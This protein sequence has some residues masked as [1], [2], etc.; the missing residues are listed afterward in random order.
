MPFKC[1]YCYALNP[2]FFMIMAKRV[3]LFKFEPFFPIIW[4]LQIHIPLITVNDVV[5]RESAPHDPTKADKN[6]V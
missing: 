1:G 3:K 4:A 6:W 2:S 5:G